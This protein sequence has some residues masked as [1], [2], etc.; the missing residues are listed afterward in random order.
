MSSFN[1]HDL[2]DI[3]NEPIPDEN[4]PEL[5]RNTLLYPFAKAFLEKFPQHR[6]IIATYENSV[7]SIADIVGPFPARPV[8]SRWRTKLRGQY[9][10]L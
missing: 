8:D 1:G 5:A 3:T 6:D 10:C 4:N 2:I 9:V 7:E